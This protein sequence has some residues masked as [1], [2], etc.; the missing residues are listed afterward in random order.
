METVRAKA[1]AR[2]VYNSELQA[3]FSREE[4]V[5]F[6]STRERRM[7]PEKKSKKMSGNVIF[8]FHKSGSVQTGNLREF[9]SLPTYL[10]NKLAL[11]YI[12]WK[13]KK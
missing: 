4:S 12:Y 9:N 5:G 13:G 7:I 3:G 1:G 2:R 11:K 6:L 8:L 10:A